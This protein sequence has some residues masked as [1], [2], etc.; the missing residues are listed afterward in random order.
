MPTSFNEL[1]DAI[2]A[3]YAK[4]NASGVVVEGPEVTRWHH[5]E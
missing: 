2:K 5:Y 4:L 1:P 3:T